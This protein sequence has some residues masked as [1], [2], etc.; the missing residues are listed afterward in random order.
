MLTYWK[1]LFLSFSTA[2]RL[3][4]RLLAYILAC[5]T[6][7]ALISTLLQLGWDYSQSVDDTKE[8]ITELARSHRTAIAASVWNMDT[9]QLGL[10]LKGLQ[11]M[12]DVQAA[13]VYEKI[14]G[15]LLERGHVGRVNGL[16]VLTQTFPLS[17]ESYDVG[18]LKIDLTLEP[19][20]Q[21]LWQKSLIILATQTLKT[22]LVSFCI[23]LIFYH[24][25]IRHLHKI[26]AFLQKL[27]A[28]NTIQPLA[29][30]RDPPSDAA[31]DEL[32]AIVISINDM[33]QRHNDD[34][35]KQLSYADNLQQEHALNIRLNEQLEQKV[36]ERTHSLEESHRELKMAYANLKNTQQ[37]LIEAEKMASLG[38][39]VTGMAHELNTPLGVSMTASR[40]LSNKLKELA[41]LPSA[42]S[43]SREHWQTQLE[44]I[45]E[46]GELLSQQLRKAVDLLNNFQQIAITHSAQQT[47]SFNIAETLHQIIVSQG[48]RLNQEHCHVSIQC[49]PA[50]EM[51]SY[52]S[53]FSRVCNHL[54]QNSL[55]HGF[56]HCNRPRTITIQV[57][58]EQ[59]EIHLDYYDNGQGIAPEL[60]PHIFEPFV[61]S[62]RAQGFSGL[63]CY[64]VYNQVVQ[65]LG[66]RI[67]C[68]SNVGNGAHFH[69]EIPKNVDEAADDS[70]FPIVSGST[71][72]RQTSIN[73]G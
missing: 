32:D 71:R 21:R 41:L 65:L 66:G 70:V 6:V 15:Q 30:E 53:A 18:E 22:L 2:H 61:T 64:I 59:G 47:S 12:P 23:M 60:L 58:A 42:E 44:A 48:H 54:L 67:K 45:G 28:S 29:L 8:R 10:Q 25:L 38:A 31:Q 46:S 62:R 20:Y 72:N 52:L 1:N 26:R 57:T 39:L 5:S 55:D 4:R 19:I 49:E 9:E 3:S 50:L 56:D 7:L 13:T 63:G 14:D 27:D 34:W 36:T 17:Y 68:Q 16:Q 37:S 33:Q 43:F 51:H 35:Q 11:Q 24:Q 40:F 73:S 69:I